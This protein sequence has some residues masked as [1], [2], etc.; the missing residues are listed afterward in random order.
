MK[1]YK[2]IKKNSSFYIQVVC[3]I[4][5]SVSILLVIGNCIKN[6]ND[7][8]TRQVHQM[9]ADVTEQNVLALQNEIKDKKNMLRGIAKGLPEEWEEIKQ[10]LTQMD[11]V[12]D[13]YE[14]KRIG[15]ILPDGTTYTS[16]EYQTNLAE[17]GVFQET[18]EQ[19]RIMISD[20]IEDTVGVRH[21]A[22]SSINV[23]TLP[24][25]EADNYTVK[26]VL[27]A[28]YETER[29]REIF[30]IDSFQGNGI[31]CIFQPNGDIL[32]GDSKLKMGEDE[33]LF[34]KIGSYSAGNAEQVEVLKQ[35][36]ADGQTGI[37]TYQGEKKIRYMYYMP[38]EVIQDQ[39]VWYLS[40]IVSKSELDTRLEVIGK[41][42]WELAA[43]LIL[44]LVLC[45]VVCFLTY[46]SQNRKRL[47]MAYIDSLTGDS[48]Y[49]EFRAQMRARKEMKGYIVAVDLADFKII[50]DI[51]GIE[52]ADELLC[53]VWGVL[54][55]ML[56]PEEMELGAHI[57]GDSFVL[58][59]TGE[60]LDSIISRILVC[61]K[62]LRGLSEDFRI[63]H[64][65]PKFGI[66]EI[67]DSRH[68]EDGYG[69]ANLAIQ[70]MGSYWK[71]SY[72]VYDDAFRQQLITERWLKDQFEIGISGHQF[73]VWYQPKV[74]PKTG[75]VVGAE[76]LVQWV[77]SNGVLRSPGE[78]IP[79]F[80][81]NGMIQQLD[82]YVFRQVCQD[83]RAWKEK[84]CPVLPISVNVSRESLYYPNLAKRY[85]DIVREE[86]VDINSV[87]LEITESAVV[88]NQK[89]E[90]FLYDFEK[91]GF[92]LLI[93]DFGNGY[94]S[95][96]ALNM[97][98][99]KTVKLDK[100]LIDH[101]GEER[102]E[103]LLAYLISMS[104]SLGLEVTAEGVETKQQVHRLLD[105]DC[106]DVQGYYYSRSI[107]REDYEKIVW[108]GVPRLGPKL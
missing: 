32:A 49:T 63:P 1:F 90:E 37:I 77:D 35:D 57:S 83:Q 18:L 78:F 75:V 79:V 68:P 20:S 60:N 10:Y 69:K 45:I 2:K 85:A 98:C 108:G 51:C 6:I 28:S 81:K 84:G 5:T 107:C 95:V 106:D 34:V 80:E 67:A 86:G 100:K 52:Q 44:T 33:N 99:F 21:G 3:V 71:D 36:F 4:L 7:E 105:L 65:I 24:I 43:L 16:D 14:F 66:C 39:S 101:I 31:S 93:D 54:K 29:F 38:V 74:T 40:T 53:K 30:S 13:L 17:W 87:Q 103:K 88:S 47:K 94:S 12:Q 70:N 96:S 25:L 15:F 26:G 27:F 97:R 11:S 58:F 8:M 72:A 59:L 19:K 41:N 73:R 104:H 82:E 102:G 55:E 61:D 89:M 91:E 64:I 62:K 56:R 22:S 9:L 42:V 92:R 46:W 48:N 50:N 23:F 76:A